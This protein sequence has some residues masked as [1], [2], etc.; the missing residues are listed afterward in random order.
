MNFNFFLPLTIFCRRSFMNFRPRFT[1]LGR[2]AILE[3]E[4]QSSDIFS[5]GSKTTTARDTLKVREKNL[6]RVLFINWLYHCVE[7][8]LNYVCARVR[9]NELTFSEN[10]LEKLSKPRQ[11]L[12]RSHS[13]IFQLRKIQLYHHLTMICRSRRSLGPRKKNKILGIISVTESFKRNTT[14][15]ERT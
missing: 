15:V 10:Y 12:K 14:S 6:A 13:S 7:F 2:D 4:N 1:G 3:P 8:C 11:I 9:N 5:L